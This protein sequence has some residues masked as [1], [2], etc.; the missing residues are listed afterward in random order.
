[1]TAVLLCITGLLLSSAL[2]AAP[3]QDYILGYIFKNPDGSVFR[4]MRYYLRD[5]NKFRVEYLATVQYHINNTELTA[6]YLTTD[7]EPHTIEILR[8]DKGLVWT[9]DTS[10]K[11]Y[12]QI[13]MRPDV[14][15]Q[16][17]TKLFINDF[18][19]LKKTGETKLLNYSCDIYQTARDG[20]TNILTVAQ[21]INV[22]LKSELSQNG[23]LLQI[24]EA[25][26]F[27][28]EKPAAD[29]FEIP[30]GYENQVN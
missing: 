23:K 6:E 26:E 8:K 22:V 20:W 21:G 12:S 13:S 18:S 16:D 10:F 4:C 9:L 3:P 15:E 11:V 30:A 27:R 14:W 28:A 19:G 7:I 1:M 29:L 25:I 5:G 17:T 2:W 24:M